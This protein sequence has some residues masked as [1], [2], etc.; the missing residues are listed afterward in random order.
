MHKTR[1]GP[2]RIL[3]REGCSLSR[4][5]SVSVLVL[6][7]CRFDRKRRSRSRGGFW[8][9]FGNEVVVGLHDH[10]TLPTPYESTRTHNTNAPASAYASHD[11]LAK[12]C[13]AL[14]ALSGTISRPPP[15]TFPAPAPPVPPS[16]GTRR[17]L[18]SPPPP[19]TMGLVSRVVANG[20]TRGD[21]LTRS[22]AP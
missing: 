4:L 1:R 18:S 19:S 2:V 8:F 17:S 22:K 3:V 6:S 5:F 21:D 12:K 16:S 13:V 11:Q 7:I 10:Y 20:D 9:G 15:I 14:P